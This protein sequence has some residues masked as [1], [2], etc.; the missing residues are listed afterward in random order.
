MSQNKE[1]RQPS[2]FTEE[3][4]EGARSGV[5]KNLFKALS[6]SRL[7]WLLAII[8]AYLA[9]SLLV[10]GCVTI[11]A[12]DDERLLLYH[13]KKADLD[14]LKKLNGLQNPE[15]GVDDGISE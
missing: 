6:G 3:E 7:F 11:G 14:E 2:L 8:F 10:Q 13:D 1:N 12:S 4:L 9:T 5:I 15:L